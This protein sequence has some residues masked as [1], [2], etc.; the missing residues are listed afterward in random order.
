MD[1][2][3]PHARDSVAA[4]VSNYGNIIPVE[5]R[6]CDGTVLKERPV[7]SRSREKHEP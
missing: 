1:C 4:P 3:D 7:N 5:S 6:S 2:E